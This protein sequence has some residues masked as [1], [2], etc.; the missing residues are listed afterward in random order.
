MVTTAEEHVRAGRPEEAMVALRDAI[1]K[2]P[3]D[4]KL[5]IFLFQLLCVLGEWEKALTQ[6]TV[7]RD[8]D[9]ASLLLAEIFTP[10]LHA[11][12]QRAEV[13]AG[14]QTPL[15]F[16]APEEWIGLLV[17][18]NHFIAQGNPAASQELRERAFDAAPAVPG[19]INDQPFD[20]I[21]DADSRLG[22]V[23]EVIME[24]KYYWIP[25]SRI[26][27]INIEAPSDLRDFVWT[28]AHFTWS[29]GGN[30][31]GFIPSRYPG[32]HAATD[33]AVRMARAT[34]WEQRGEDLFIGLG[35]RL[36]ATSEAEIPL[37][38]LRKLQLSP[39]VPAA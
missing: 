29:N 24:G 6:L 14:R 9:A 23:L 37:L 19:T 35:Q 32:S 11:E 26:Q 27:A 5:R 10:V 31:P 8:L 25:F 30:A 20:W 28:P 22:P 16:G 21:A 38:E 2:A 15:V 1:K 39:A 3:A 7:L 17:Q 33:D 36:F 18:A 12:Q 4:P 34:T 13:F